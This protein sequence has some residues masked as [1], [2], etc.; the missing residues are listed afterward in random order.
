[1]LRLVTSV[2]RQAE[3]Y[4]LTSTQLT[5]DIEEQL[6]QIYKLKIVRLPELSMSNPL[7]LYQSWKEL[8]KALQMIQ[9]DLVHVHGAWNPLLYLMER[10]ARH[11]GFVT[12]ISTYGGMAPEILNID[13]FK[14]R[15]LPLLCYQAPLIRHSTS[16]L[17]INQKEW[18]DIRNLNLK[19][20]V[21]ILPEITIRDGSTDV[22]STALLAAYRKA[23]DSS[24]KRF[25]TADEEIFVER[26]VIAATT[27]EPISGSQYMGAEDS[28]SFRRVFLYAYDEDVID[29]LP[30]GAHRLFCQMPQPQNVADIPR[31]VDKKAKKRGGLQQ[32]PSPVR[33]IKISNE[34]KPLE[35]SVVTSLLKAQKE[36]IKR[37]TLRHKSELYDLFRNKDF[38]EDVVAEELSRLRLRRFTKK[39]Q[40][41]LHDMYNMPQGFDIF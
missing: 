8:K 40:R 19:K 7:K 39:I 12:C 36:G 38:D 32:L 28:L 6:T 35:Y 31:Y 26:C 41:K 10:T 11:N 1:M 29:I 17:A 15:M 9:P 33:K 2:S 13:F 3:S 30:A 34:D 21:E 20:R 22:L 25:I 16:L 4:L 18:E 5:P 14:K 27:K 24:Y 37:L 23:I